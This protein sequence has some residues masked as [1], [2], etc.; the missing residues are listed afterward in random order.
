M[1]LKDLCCRYRSRRGDMGLAVSEGRHYHV[2]VFSDSYG[3]FF[4]AILATAASMVFSLLLLEQSAWLAWHLRQH[5]QRRWRCH[6]KQRLRLETCLKKT[7]NE[8]KNTF[9]IPRGVILICCLLYAP[10]M[11]YAHFF[12]WKQSKELC[13]WVPA[14]KLALILVHLQFFAWE[15]RCG[16]GKNGL[17]SCFLRRFVKYA[18]VCCNF[19]WML[20]FCWSYM[21]SDASPKCCHFVN[22]SLNAFTESLDQALP[23]QPKIIERKG[24]QKSERTARGL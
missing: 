1:G 17:D 23:L 16:W 21:D 5:T 3:L 14:Q 12:S 6:L 11:S 15:G 20:S 19:G 8:Q 22:A 13:I 24:S 7:E 2:F 18:A 10:E 4:Q 9:G